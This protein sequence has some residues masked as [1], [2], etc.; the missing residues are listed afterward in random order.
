V[1]T[2]VER[3]PV[4]APEVPGL[5]AL[6]RLENQSSRDAP[7][8]A[9]LD[10]P[11]GPEVHGEAPDRSYERRIGVVPTAER[12]PAEGQTLRLQEHLGVREDTLECLARAARPGRADATVE[13][14]LPG[15][16]PIAL[17]GGLASVKGPVETF[18]RVFEREPRRTT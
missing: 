17:L 9:G 3:R 13:M 6:K 15:A 16:I 5:P 12:A 11:L 8:D 2:P 1:Q 14:T 10:D 7:A 4:N 18:H